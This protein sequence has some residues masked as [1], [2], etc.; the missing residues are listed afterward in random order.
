MDNNTFQLAIAIVASI[1]VV[2]L[3]WIGW[4]ARQ[5]EANTKDAKTAVLDV[6][7]AIASV[8]NGITVAKDAAIAQANL[9]AGELAGRD[10]EVARQ[11]AA[12]ALL[13]SNERTTP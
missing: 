5:A 4:K 9:K 2:A 12:K 13:T 6:H 10:F 8:A 11:A 3:A 1:Q 7:E